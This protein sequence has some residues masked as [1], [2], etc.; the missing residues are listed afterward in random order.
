MIILI[1]KNITTYVPINPEIDFRII[2]VEL[3]IIIN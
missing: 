2:I 3:R 1:K